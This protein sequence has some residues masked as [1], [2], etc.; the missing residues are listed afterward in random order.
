MAGEERFLAKNQLC[1]VCHHR[2]TTHFC[3][4]DL[5]QS[6]FCYI[7]VSQHLD[8]PSRLPHFLLPVDYLESAKDPTIRKRL[9]GLALGKEDLER[10]VAD[11]LQWKSRFVSEAERFQRQYQV[12]QQRFESSFDHLHQVLSSCV[13]EGIEEVQVNI[14]DQQPNPRNPVAKQ[15]WKGGESLELAQCVSEFSTMFGQLRTW[16]S[17]ATVVVDVQLPGVAENFEEEGFLLLRESADRKEYKKLKEELGDSDDRKIVEGKE[18]VEYESKYYRKTVVRIKQSPKISIFV[19]F[20]A[21]TALYLGCRSEGQVSDLYFPNV[22]SRAV[23]KTWGR[24][25]GGNSAQSLVVLG[26]IHLEPGAYK[27]QWDPN[28]QDDGPIEGQINGYGTMAYWNGDIYEG[29]WKAGKRHGNGRLISAQGDL[30]QGIWLEDEFSSWGN[31]TFADGASQSGQWKAGKLHGFGAINASQSIFFGEFKDNKKV[32]IGLEYA[33]SSSFSVGNWKD[34]VYNGLVGK[35]DKEAVIWGNYEA[36]VLKGVWEKG[37]PTA[38]TFH[39]NDAFSQKYEKTANKGRETLGNLVDVAS[40]TEANGLEKNSEGQYRGQTTGHGLRSGYG[41]Q[42]YTDGSSYQG[43][44]HNDKKHGSGLWK[45]AEGQVCEG[46]WSEGEFAGWGVCAYPDGVIKAGQWKG[47]KLHGFG[48]IQRPDRLLMEGVHIDTLGPMLDLE[49]EFTVGTWENSLAHGPRL[50]YRKGEMTWGNYQLGKLQGNISVLEASGARYVGEWS[51][52]LRQGRG[53][54]YYP[55]ERFEGLWDKGKVTTGSYTYNDTF[56]LVHEGEMIKRFQTAVFDPVLNLGSSWLVLAVL[57]IP[58]EGLYTGHISSKGLRQGYGVQ[59]YSDNSTYMGNW[60][61][62]TRNGQ[63]KLITAQGDIYDGTWLKSEFSGWGKCLFS[64]GT[65]QRGQWKAGKLHGFGQVKDA[66]SQTMGEYRNNTMSGVGLQ[67]TS[68]DNFTVGEFSSGKLVGKGLICTPD[69]ISWGDYKSGRIQ[70]HKAQ[71]LDEFLIS[72]L[73]GRNI[74]WGIDNTGY[75]REAIA[76][77]ADKSVFLTAIGVGSPKS[78]TDIWFVEVRKGKSTNGRLV[79]ADTE[80][81]HLKFEGQSFVKIPLYGAVLLEADAYYTLRLAYRL[82]TTVYA[83]QGANNVLEKWGVRF[84]FE[85]A[86]F[87]NGDHSPGNHEISSPLRD[88]YFLLP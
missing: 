66:T 27:G 37:L 1:F 60:E 81:S 57:K 83:T 9:M 48:L 46:A 10:Q 45:S 25:D 7:C 15:L 6:V 29:A 3:I 12:F 21:L 74:E 80:T 55:A 47:G 58:N 84:E 32:G 14:F 67:Y 18:A 2:N 87:D 5:K 40:L 76:F 54:A 28:F 36:G 13:S 85:E 51:Q 35:I 70:T 23:L 20:I 50:S 19:A 65:T 42:N 78:Q 34:G 68:A 24:Y 62:N 16:M 22:T 31:C 30:C 17:E 64:N 43:N 82:D 77:K 63:G 59:V 88:F 53:V 73:A 75:Q 69:A 56:R 11:V 79:Y 71:K 52:G 4:C 86:S 61:N 41:V 72:R 38:G 33:S 39:Y 49:S 8:S 44:W 26:P